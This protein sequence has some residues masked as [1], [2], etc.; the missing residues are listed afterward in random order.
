MHHVYGHQKQDNGNF[1]DAVIPNYFDVAD[2]PYMPRPGPEDYCLFIGRVI[3]RKGIEVAVEATRR[4]GVK[5]K[6]AGQGVAN[7]AGN[8][9]FA[10][11]GSV[12]TGDHIEYVGFADSARRAEL[13]GRARAVLVPT[14][15][16]EPFGGVAIE[17]NF[18]GT[19]VI[20]TDFGA[21][22]ETVRHGETGYRCHTV[23]EFAWAI[24]AV[25]R[26]DRAHVRRHAMENYSLERVAPMYE[27]FFAMVLGL[28]NA[29]NDWYGKMP[30]KDLA[31][32]EGR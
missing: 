26:L 19:P 23:R 24:E 2:F 3:N 30:V 15:Y 7:C 21:F 27:H 4:A 10:S 9:I 25:K 29:E 14:L 13:M 1:Y 32:L 8:K 17:A 16:I 12:Y 18:C 28:Y 31:W 22:T 11:D 20:T 5:L 6:I